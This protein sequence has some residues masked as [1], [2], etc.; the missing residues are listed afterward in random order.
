MDSST[1][2][3]IWL[4]VIILVPII[5]AVVLFIWCDSIAEVTG[6][7]WGLPCKFGGGF[8]GY[9]AVVWLISHHWPSHEPTDQVYTVLGKVGVDK[10]PMPQLTDLFFAEGNGNDVE[11]TPDGAFQK[12]MVAK[13]VQ[14]K[15]K[16][17]SLSINWKGQTF[18][19]KTIHLD[20]GERW[21]NNTDNPD[22]QIIISGHEITIQP[23]IALKRILEQIKPFDPS[24]PLPSPTV[25]PSPPPTAAVD[26]PIPRVTRSK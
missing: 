1:Q 4:L 13:V 26:S 19:G 20:P 8:A 24:G 22:I 12:P 14:G 16:L 21:M 7:L 5:P 6:A 23:S 3:L 18:G 9:F 25:V 2:D 10:G 11:Y 15:L 17:P